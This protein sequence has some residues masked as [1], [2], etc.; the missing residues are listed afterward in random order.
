MS[1]VSF[2][3]PGPGRPRLYST[4]IVSGVKAGRLA[5]RM[6]VPGAVAALGPMLKAVPYLGLILAVAETVVVTYG[7]YRR[8]TNEVGCTDELE[9][10]GELAP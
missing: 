3:H 1:L 6:K 7:A 5:V 9:R 10:G 8:W 4:L 2:F